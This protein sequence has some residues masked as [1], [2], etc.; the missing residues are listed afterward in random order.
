MLDKG[1]LEDLLVKLRLGTISVES[2]VN[3]IE[4]NFYSPD[5]NDNL[6][7]WQK[8][9]CP[10]DEV[11]ECKEQSIHYIEMIIN[12]FIKK[13]SNFI[14]TGVE[15][16][17]MLELA[18]KYKNC[19]FSYNIGIISNI[20][21]KETLKYN[22]TVLIITSLNSDD[23]IIKE[24]ETIFDMIGINVELYYISKYE[25]VAM[26]VV[27]EYLLKSDAIIVA[28]DKDIRLTSIISNISTKPVILLSKN[29]HTEEYMLSNGV[30]MAKPESAISATMAVL[31]YIK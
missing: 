14:L 25:T 31:R 4:N 28:Y 19:I 26:Q 23:I 16:N 5:N 20:E 29:K 9:G 1:E 18:S 8:L 27:K 2:A 3:E 17:I 6:T 13:H 21:K 30:L 11:V 10:F 7:I 15:E 22:K 24:L 12:Q